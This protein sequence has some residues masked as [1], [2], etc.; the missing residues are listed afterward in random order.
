MSYLYFPKIKQMTL[1][2]LFLAI[3]GLLFSI[4]PTSTMA[5]PQVEIVVNSPTIYPPYGGG[6]CDSGWNQIDG[7]NGAPAYLTLNTDGS[8][9]STNWGEWHPDLPASGVYKVEAFI[10]TH[11][12]MHWNCPPLDINW[13]TTQ[14]PYTIHHANGDTSLFGN[15][16]PLFNSWLDLGSYAF[17]AGSGGWVELHDLNTESALSHTIS[18]SAMRFTL[19]S[20][21]TT[22]P[23]GGIT[24]PVSGSTFGPATI[25]IKADA[26]DEQGGSGVQYVKFWALYDGQWHTIS[27]DSTPPYE[28]DWSTPVNLRSQ[29]VVLTIHVIDNAGNTAMDPGGTRTINF[30]QS[31]NNPTVS[32]NWVPSDKRAYLNQRSLS[33]SGDYK[34]GAASV[35][36]VLAMNGVIG[37]DYNAMATKANQIYVPQNPLWSLKQNLSDHGLNSLALY[38]SVDAGWEALK[39]EIDAGFPAIILSDRFTEGHYFVAVGYR[40]NGGVR[41]LIAYDPYGQWQGSWWQYDVN[42]TSSSSEKGK[43]VYYNFDA[44]WGYDGSN[45]WILE[46]STQNREANEDLL[47]GIPTTPPDLVSDEPE[48][49]GLYPHISVIVD[50]KVYLPL[51]K[52]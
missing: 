33:P 4:L 27:T 23:S 20:T 3:V 11:A 38:L 14:A 48:T 26:W 42:S 5:S 36:M 35:A 51:M 46:A 2:G 7:Y 39:G 31:E 24:S 17:S 12:P 15:Q 47:T 18:F 30:V 49:I 9:P 45:G 22:P 32:E 1:T 6:M 29:Q 44:V 10:P 21:D 19:E 28:S 50:Y 37:R 43:W 41:E 40:Q 13:D 52:Q 25:A 34:C 8:W 16:Q